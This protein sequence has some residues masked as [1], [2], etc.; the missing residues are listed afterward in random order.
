MENAVV[1]LSGGLDSTTALYWAVRKGWGVY[2]LSVQYG[3]K[4]SFEIDCAKLTTCLLPIKGH[5][6]ATIDMGGW[7]NSSLTCPS[8]EIASTS[9]NSNDIPDTYVPAR[10]MV[11]LSLAASYA[12]TVQATHLVIGVSEVDYSGYVDCRSPFIKAM[13]EAVN[14][15]TALGEIEKQRISIETPFLHMTK[16]EEIALGM[17]WGIDY[18][19]TWSCYRNRKKP[20]NDCES[21]QLRANA[22]LQAGYEDPL[23][24]NYKNKS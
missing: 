5:K 18:S 16:A 24:S 21:C 3:Q 8:V 17:S 14:R 1:L 20:C 9:D 11:L 22:F 2:A 4:S 19:L 23:L 15:G 7:G 6:V 10:N 13:E 12:E